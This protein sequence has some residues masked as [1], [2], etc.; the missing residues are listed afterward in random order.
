MK[1][2]V[3]IW[4]H[5]FK[6][7]SGR[8]WGASTSVLSCT[9]TK[10]S[11][12]HSSRGSNSKMLVGQ[13]DNQPRALEYA[14]GQEGISPCSAICFLENTHVMM[15]TDEGPAC[16]INDMFLLLGL[17]VSV[18]HIHRIYRDKIRDQLL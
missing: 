13:Q 1:C 17:E 5:E 14:T 9:S 18:F 7:W 11:N 4:S 8:T 15:Y 6:L 3:M 12:G 2:T 16:P 10:H